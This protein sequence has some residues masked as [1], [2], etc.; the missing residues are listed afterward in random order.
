[1]SSD[2]KQ[3]N[4]S[5]TELA[6]QTQLSEQSINMMTDKIKGMKQQHWEAVTQVKAEIKKSRDLSAQ[7]RDSLNEARAKIG[8]PPTKIKQDD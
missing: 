3:L 7:I 1:M 2:I 5:V 6:V 4:K 8:L